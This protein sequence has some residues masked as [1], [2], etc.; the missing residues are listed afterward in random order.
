[1][2]S[3]QLKTDDWILRRT[4][5]LIKKG[6]EVL[7]S[8]RPKPDSIIASP[9]LNDQAYINWR[10]QSL[11]FLT[12]LLGPD[13]TYTCNFNTITEVG[14]YQSTVRQGIGILEAVSED[15]EQ[16]FIETVRQLIV[17]EVWSDLFDHAAY[18]LG[19]GYSAPAASLT[20]AILENGLRSIAGSKGVPVRPADN[21][22][23]LNQKLA[24]KG[25]YN[26]LTQKKIGVWT[27]TGTPQ[28]TENSPRLTTGM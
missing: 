12:D 23:S 25:V 14:G 20:G 8:H 1:M 5:A 7:A 9:T 3:D 15:I 6:A 28:I 2:G 17:A 26:R 19:N 16:G 21:L 11:S 24:E 22:M 13:H 18:L 27:D 10:T 4:I